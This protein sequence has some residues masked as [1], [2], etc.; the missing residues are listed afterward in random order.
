[1]K[2][3]TKK[4]AA[5]LC[6]AVLCLSL[7]ACGQN[8]D[9][10]ESPAEETSGK[11]TDLNLLIN[12]AFSTLDPGNLSLTADFKLCRQIYEPLYKLDNDGNEI[13]VLATE[14]SVSDD[15][16][17]WNFKLREGVKFHN[18]D[19]LTTQDV[20]YS[21]NRCMES[22]YM[23]TYAEPLESVTAI[24][25]TTVEIKLKAPF[26]PLIE[27]LSYLGVVSQK[28]AEENM[29]DQG[30]LGFN[31]CGTGPYMH[32]ES[33]PDVS[34]TLASNPDYWDGEPSIKTLNFELITD[35]STALT[36]F[37]AGE[38][39][40]VAVPSASWEEVSS[41]DAYASDAP[42]TN[43]CL[44]LMFNTQQAPFDNQKL[45]QAIAYAID[46][47]AIIDMAM[48]GL[49]EPASTLATPYMFGYQEE[50][51]SY[52]YD[53]E[54]AK[55]LLA[56]AGYPDGLDIGSLKTMGGTY[57]EKVMQV[58]QGQLQ[59]I[60]ITSQIEGMDGNA[61]V[62]D[63]ISG[64]FGLANMGQ[65]MTQDYDFLKSYFCKDYIDGLNMA[66]YQNDEVDALFTE[67]ASTVDKDARMAT[68]TKIEEITQDACAYVPLYNMQ[69]TVAWNKDLNYDPSIL[70]TYYKD[71]TWK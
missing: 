56:E 25:D 33:T 64:N 7:G 23:Q 6:T 43:H 67:G 14:Y 37:E 26:S 15:Q 50:H 2:K 16:L 61:L 59:A 11:R 48:D 22:A 34:V 57:F 4:L 60:G 28:F 24:D 10:K 12:D 31:T 42:L 39:D 29:D 30:L 18:G 38:L 66:R 3:R 69:N 68:Y 36:A 44:Y 45:R 17:T 46:R 27:N 40:I 32:K 62:S 9:S 20:A 1:M 8:G 58:V 35:A 13:A 70:I 54:K 55:E 52:E 21:L 5:L 63:C 41:N 19:P 51:P 71:I 49:A 65:S 47:Q 53:P